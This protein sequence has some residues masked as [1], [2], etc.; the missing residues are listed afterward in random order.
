MS[1]GADLTDDPLGETNMSKAAQI[2]LPILATTDSSEQSESSEF[3]AVILF[4]GI[5]LAA[6]LIAIISGV[7]GVWY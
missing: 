4:S 2:F 1:V 5:G 6:S 7:Q 3:Y